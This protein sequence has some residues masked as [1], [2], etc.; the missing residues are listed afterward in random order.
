MVKPAFYDNQ[1]FAL[2]VDG[3][4][5]YAFLIDENNL[6]S[7]NL[8]SLAD[9]KEHFAEKERQ[10]VLAE[11][12]KRQAAIEAQ[13]QREI[14]IKEE[15]RIYEINRQKLKY[16]EKEKREKDRILSIYRNIDNKVA[17]FIPWWF[18][19]STVGLISIGFNYFDDI[20]LNS[21]WHSF[22]YDS[23]GLWVI[24]VGLIEFVT[25][26]IIVEYFPPIIYYL[27]LVYIYKLRNPDDINAIQYLLKHI[28]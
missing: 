1:I 25:S 12:R 17:K 20:F 26:I 28:L 16:E 9:L 10:A 5:D 2:Q 27:I 24:L 23:I 6:P 13:R 3:T 15:Q 21:E 19:L 11:E 8:R 4:N 22:L 18:P 14:K 7:T